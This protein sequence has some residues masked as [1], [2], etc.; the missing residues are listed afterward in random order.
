[1]TQILSKQNVTKKSGINNYSVEFFHIYSDETINDTHKLSL[2]YLKEAKKS[3]SFNHDLILL[4]DDYNP[5]KFILDETELFE[6]LKS[7]DCLPDFW[8]YEKDL[9]PIAKL[10]LENVSSSKIK[11]NYMGYIE[12]HNKYPC[13]L[14]TASWYLVRLGAVPGQEIIKSSSDQKFIPAS[15][16]I[17][18]LPFDYKPVELRARKLIKNSIFSDYQD[19][20]QDLFIPKSSGRTVT[21]W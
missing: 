18:I 12:Q 17:N 14:L 20:V 19:E 3:W 21:L 1:M 15:K 10:L 9:V 16:L 5:T 6:Y 2:H 8:A 4:I 11:K 7:E 13:S